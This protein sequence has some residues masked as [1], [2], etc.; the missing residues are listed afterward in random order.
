[1]TELDSHANMVVVGN[2][3]EI[4]ADTGKTANV[5]AFSPEHET[6][7]SVRIVDAAVKWICPNTDTNYLMIV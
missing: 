5:K 4:L 2:N 1:M 3:C 6:L 7:D